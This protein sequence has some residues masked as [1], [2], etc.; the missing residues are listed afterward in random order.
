MKNENT[1][2]TSSSSTTNTTYRN[3]TRALIT[4]RPTA[5]IG[6][7]AG[8][9]RSRSPNYP[10][11]AETVLAHPGLQ[12]VVV[13]QRL[14]RNLCDTPPQVIQSAQLRHDPRNL[15]RAHTT[16]FHLAYG[17]CSASAGAGAGGTQFHR[18][19]RQIHAVHLHPYSS[20]HSALMVGVGAGTWLPE[21]VQ[22]T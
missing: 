3:E 11:L 21:W 18:C 6:A 12:V 15:V 7:S 8:I 9:R 20:R 17:G 13:H 10:G 16:A 2:N 19:I 5:S 4:P 14:G 22:G 1:Y